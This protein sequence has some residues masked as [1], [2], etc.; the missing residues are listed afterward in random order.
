MIFMNTARRLREL[1]AQPAMIVAPG[2]FN[3]MTARI[4]EQ[5][6]FQAVYM[7]GGGTSIAHGY[8]DMGLLTLTE[9]ADNAGM[10]ARSV[11]LPVIADADTGYGNQLNV[12]RT[13]REYEQRGVAGLHLEDQ[14]T[15][16]RCGHMASKEVVSR[17][18]YLANIRAAV[19]ARSNP[20]F[21]I[22][23]RTDARSVMGLDESIARASEALAAGAD[24]A[25]IEAAESVEEIAEIPRRIGSPCVINIAPG[26]RS[27]FVSLDDVQEMGYKLAI[28]PGVLLTA[29]I[30]ACDSALADLKEGR[31]P[32]HEYT[33]LKV[34]D[35]FR[36]FGADEWDSLRQ[37]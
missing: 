10:L 9:M 12:T 30:S 25:F 24:M 8:P 6:G 14:V 2:A 5:S 22:I 13:V 28:V 7:T 26:G 33:G 4:I 18:E 19:K 16:K 32:P 20:D 29:I 36:R 31:Y 17:Q 27:P 21:L 34:S 37:Q 15:P 23:A 3:G 35:M 1:L 11:S